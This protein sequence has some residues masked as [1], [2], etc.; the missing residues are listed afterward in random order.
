[1]EE[2]TREATKMTRNLD[3]EYFLGEQK[4]LRELIFRPDGQSKK[5]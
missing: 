1:M 4:F 2:F 5:G 3:M